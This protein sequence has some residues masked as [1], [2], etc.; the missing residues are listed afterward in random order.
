[1]TTSLPRNDLSILIP[2][3]ESLLAPYVVGCLSQIQGWKT[4]ILSD[5]PETLTRYP[6]HKQDFLV[7][8]KSGT[9]E[10]W[11]DTLRQIA[12]R[13]KVDVVLPVDEFAIRALSIYGHE[14]ASL[15]SIA[16]I[17]KTNAFDLVADKWSSALFFKQNNLPAPDTIRYE[18]GRQFEQS[19]QSLSFPVLTKPIHAAGGKGIQYWESLPGLRAHLEKSADPQKFIIQ[20]FIDGF[21]TD[22]SVL[23]QDGRILA[24]TIQ[25][26]LFPERLRFEVTQQIRFVHNEEV[27]RIAERLVGALQW[28]GAAHIDM[29]FDLQNGQYKILEINPR[30]WAT[31]LGSMKAGVNFPYLACLASLGLEFPQPGYRAIPFSNGGT[32]AVMNILYH[33]FRT[34]IRKIIWSIRIASFREKLS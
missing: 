6:S 16:P 9:Y 29:R 28:S 14:L 15:T 24:Y 7:R 3:G 1:M 4:H 25:R 26:E 31:I 2:D 18:P 27:L 8:R 20:S 32:M 11:T 17:P 22:C 19:L 10:E 30:Y 12:T 34:M 33:I 23:C 5:D 21:N 13:K